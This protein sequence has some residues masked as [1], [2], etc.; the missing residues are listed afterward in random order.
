MPAPYDLTREELAD[1]LDG[2]PAYRVRQVW[3][4]LHVRVQRPEE[5]T[6]LPAG[7]AC[8]RWPPRCH[9]P[10]ARSPRQSA[11]DGETTKWLWALGDGATGRDGAHALSRIG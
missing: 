10:C 6:E 2:E 1:I 8:R 9:P 4:G 5:L 7:A 3:D 11:D